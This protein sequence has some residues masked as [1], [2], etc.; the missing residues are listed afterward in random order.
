MSRGSRE[1]ANAHFWDAGE[2]SGV[3]LGSPSIDASGENEA[4]LL[5]GGVGVFKVTTEPGQR[6]H[7]FEVMEIADSLKESKQP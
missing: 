6:L 2:P 4:V 5:I 7:T 3:E 1:R